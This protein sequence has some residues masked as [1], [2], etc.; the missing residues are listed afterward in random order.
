MIEREK[1]GFSAICLFAGMID[2]EIPKKLEDL[3]KKLGL[4]IFSICG[5]KVSK[6]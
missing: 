5:V 4:N 2:Y 3:D 1:Q 6:I